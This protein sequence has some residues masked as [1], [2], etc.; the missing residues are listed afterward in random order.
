VTTTLRRRAGSL[1]AYH[2]YALVVVGSLVV[3]GLWTHLDR[4]PLAAT[5]L[6]VGVTALSWLGWRDA[7]VSLGDQ[8]VSRDG[9]MAGLLIGAVI[10]L[11]LA[12]F[13]AVTWKQEFPFLGDHDFHLVAQLTSWRFWA[14]HLIAVG[15]VVATGL[16][17]H[18]LRLL[19][20]WLPLCVAA[21]VVWSWRA[22][23]PW[24][25]ARYPGSDHFFELP[26]AALGRLTAW[27]SPLNVGRLYHVLV[28]VAWL[29]V[30]R[31]WILGRWPG[32]STGHASSI[33]C[34]E[35][36]CAS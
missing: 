26:V 32:T 16:A 7:P 21:M 10:V 18:R 33:R 3:S 19:A 13:L 15:L 25:Y 9:A 34:R 4:T 30:L 29:F 23:L 35:R 12:T 24:L 36:P 22:E 17:A 14:P 6:F 20:Y 1:S 8:L 5:V 2:G 28:V 31:P 11:P 27:D